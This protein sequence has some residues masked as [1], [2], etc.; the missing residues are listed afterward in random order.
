MVLKPADKFNSNKIFPSVRVEST[1]L[2]IFIN[3]FNVETIVMLHYYINLVSY[4]IWQQSCY[5]VELTVKC[6]NSVVSS[7]CGKNGRVSL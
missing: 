6:C 4:F 3:P 7:S 2:F 1:V 5:K